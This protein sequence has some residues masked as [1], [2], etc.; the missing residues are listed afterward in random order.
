MANAVINGAIGGIS[1]SITFRTNLASTDTDCSETP[2]F[3][4]LTITYLPRTNVLYQR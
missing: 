4:D 1:N 3:E 2:V